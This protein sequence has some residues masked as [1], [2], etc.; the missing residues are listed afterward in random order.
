MSVLSTVLLLLTTVM[1]E[2]LLVSTAL[3]VDLESVILR[4]MMTAEG[5]MV[6]TAEDMT[7]AEV[8]DTL[9]SAAVTRRSAEAEAE[10]GMDLDKEV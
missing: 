6:A 4:R 8:G 7:I 2:D 5:M 9:R 10:D 1:R 3:A